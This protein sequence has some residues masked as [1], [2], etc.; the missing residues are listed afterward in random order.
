MIF[1]TGWLLFAGE[2][3][4]KWQSRFFR[5]R[6]NKLELL[7]VGGGDSS[8]QG[9]HFHVLSG[10][11]VQNLVLSQFPGVEEEVE[12]QPRALEDIEQGGDGLGK[13]KAQEKDKEVAKEVQEAPRGAVNLDDAMG[14]FVFGKKENGGLIEHNICVSTWKHEP[15]HTGPVKFLLV[16]RPGKP[17]WRMALEE[18][19]Q[20]DLNK[21][22]LTIERSLMRGN[23][24]LAG[25]ISTPGTINWNR[26]YALLL[27][28]GH[29]LLFKDPS[30]DNLRREF[31]LGDSECVVA[32]LHPS[33]KAGSDEEKE[34][35]DGLKKSYQSAKSSFIDTVTLRVNHPS[36][37][38]KKG[39]LI[40]I[41][42]LDM[43][44]GATSHYNRFKEWSR[45]L[46]EILHSAKET[47]AQSR[48]LEGQLQLFCKKSLLLRGA[49]ESRIALER[50]L[51]SKIFHPTPAM[52]ELARAGFSNNFR[53]RVW[54]GYCAAL[55]EKVKGRLS[56]HKM[57]LVKAATPGWKYPL[58]S[59][60]SEV[61]TARVAIQNVDGSSALLLMLKKIN[62]AFPLLMISD[63]HVSI[64]KFLIDVQNE[65][66]DCTSLDEVQGIFSTMMSSELLCY[67]VTVSPRNNH[68]K[69]LFGTADG[70]ESETTKKSVDLRVDA[71]I[72]LDL[73]LEVAP[74]LESKQIQRLGNVVMQWM[75]SIFTDGVPLSND[76]TARIWDVLL[77]K[78]DQDDKFQLRNFMVRASVS[79]LLL[80]RELLSESN[81]S[82]WPTILSTCTANLDEGFADTLI[83]ALTKERTLAK[84]CQWSLL[85]ERRSEKWAAIEIESRETLILVKS[86]K[87]VVEDANLLERSI[88]DMFNCANKDPNLSERDLVLTFISPVH[89]A[90]AS[91][92]RDVAA[93]SEMITIFAASLEFFLS[94]ASDITPAICGGSELDLVIDELNLGTN[95]AFDGSGRVVISHLIVERLVNSMISLAWA[96]ESSSAKCIAHADS[97]A[98]E[99]SSMIAKCVDLQDRDLTPSSQGSSAASSNQAKSLQSSLSGLLSLARPQGHPK[100]RDD[101]PLSQRTH[102]DLFRSLQASLNF[103]DAITQ[104]IIDTNVAQPQEEDEPSVASIS[105]NL[106]GIFG[107]NIKQLSNKVVPFVIESVADLRQS[108]QVHT[109]NNCG[110][111]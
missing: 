73:F 40:C 34:V 53:C 71:Q 37:S 13:A 81:P 90:L 63:H 11:G 57:M 75:M 83:F 8:K 65:N 2:D 108:T 26:R 94:K 103:L 30:L 27:S 89:S 10:Q 3:A 86:W 98:F 18:G 33:P 93:F 101:L 39:Y 29:L 50:T 32:P 96:L 110:S 77:V 59:E 60:I 9:L 49:D 17:L 84:A 109:N 69:R 79:I 72:V 19:S 111:D 78:L 48:S 107:Q 58:A 99:A 95:G 42:R 88:L 102:D 104:C 1:W 16:G 87:S 82:D 20:C 5:V 35:V 22:F 28:T 4:H 31:W 100:V 85:K 21:L 68:L 23:V 14:F 74:G 46:D 52:V 92:S 56:Q 44:E 97:R 15:F 66:K 24:F 12:L 25:W 76:V 61:A 45:V 41:E 43:N 70:K 106:A 64:A 62:E 7:D 36:I 54:A 51:Q 91:V 38:D 67:S 47:F 55:S 80:W 105:F 6:D